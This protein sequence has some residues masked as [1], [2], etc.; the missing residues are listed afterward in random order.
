MKTLV[1]DITSSRYYIL[2]A[3]ICILLGASTYLTSSLVTDDIYFKSLGDQLSYE[4][5]LDAINFQKKW[6]W[7]QYLLFPFFY[8]LKFFLITG[9][10]NVGIV[11]AGDKAE[12][13]DL[14]KIVTISEVVFVIPQ[15]ITFIWFSFIFTNYGL[16]DLRTFYPLSVLSLIPQGS[17]DFWMI[18]PL[19]TFNA[20]HILY[21]MFLVF[22]VGLVLKKSFGKAVALVASS[23]GFGLM[24][25]IIF[26]IFLTV[27][28]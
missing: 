14:F 2:F 12:T 19:Q 22:S 20:F 18:Y 5:I 27:H 15:L 17:L 3:I 10:L 21:L 11:L 16:D 7:L 26:Y 8:F 23:Y 1:Y 4:R 25:W 28:I 24:L 6:G 9:L 13:S